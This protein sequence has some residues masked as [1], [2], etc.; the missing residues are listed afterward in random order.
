MENPILVSARPPSGGATTSADSVRIA[1]FDVGLI[2]L[3]VSETVWTPSLRHVH[4][5]RALLMNVYRPYESLQMEDNVR[6]AADPVAPTATATATAT[7]TITMDLTGDGEG[8]PPAAAWP[9]P[10]VVPVKRKKTPKPKKKA[11]PKR[12]AKPKYVQPYGDGSGVGHSDLTDTEQHRQLLAR[13]VTSKTPAAE[14]WQRSVA[15]LVRA[16]DLMPW[17]LECDV[18]L[19]EQQ[20]P[21]NTSMRCLSYVLLSYFDV[22]RRERVARG[23]AQQQLVLFPSTA[24]LSDRVVQWMGRT[25]SV[26]TSDGTATRSMAALPTQVCTDTYAARKKSAPKIMSALF[27]SETDAV[28][29][30]FG[31]WLRSQRAEKHNVCDALLQSFAYLCRE[32]GGLSDKEADKEVQRAANKATREANKAAREAKKQARAVKKAAA[33]A[34]KASCKRKGGDSD[35]DSEMAPPKPSKRAKKS[36]KE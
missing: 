13:T 29:H 2:N 7:A 20:D 4:V 10:V 23:L 34:N 26:E 18:V 9:R 25:W 15:L 19:V 8:V 1:S 35:G 6:A 32:C 12:V 21:K 27:G 28:R 24:K 17:L 14:K 30:P 11:P 36:E 3:G 22:R 33:E 5:A 16:L 31:A